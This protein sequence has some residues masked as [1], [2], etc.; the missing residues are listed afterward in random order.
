[1]TTDRPYRAAMSREAAIEELQAN[2]GTQFEQR[3][4]EAVC[5]V[6][7]SDASF[8]E[9]QYADAVR[10]VLAGNPVRPEPAR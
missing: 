4:V 10:A 5:R 6:V 9:E 8:T 1:M 3:V 2:S 7:S